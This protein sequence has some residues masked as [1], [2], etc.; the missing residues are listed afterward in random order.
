[1]GNSILVSKT[2]ELK[3]EEDAIQLSKSILNNVSLKE[4]STGGQGQIKIIRADGSIKD[5][6]FDL[7]SD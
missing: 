3:S 1:V 4:I 6:V 5:V 7:K 2:R